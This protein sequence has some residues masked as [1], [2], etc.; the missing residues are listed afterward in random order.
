MVLYVSSNSNIKLCPYRRNCINVCQMPYL[1]WAVS[2]K[3]LDRR[4]AVIREIMDPRNQL[5]Y[6][7][8]TAENIEAMG[9]STYMKILRAH[10]APSRD[11]CL[12]ISKT[13]TQYFCF[14]LDDADESF[15]DQVV[16]KFALKQHSRKV[17]EER[18]E[19]EARARAWNRME[20]RK[21][22]HADD[23]SGARN[24]VQDHNTTNIEELEWLKVADSSSDPPKVIMV[25][26]FLTLST[27]IR[28]SYSREISNYSITGY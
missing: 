14:T 18:Q 24:E 21:W 26:F 28:T 7:E 2:G 9:G 12:H 25:L 1:H 23:L 5:D 6:I 19:C 22:E 8:P 13:L 16:Y 20:R 17:E 4:N 15:Q 10:L 3:S 27:H 11:R